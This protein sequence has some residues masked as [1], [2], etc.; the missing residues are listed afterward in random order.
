MY[1]FLFCITNADDGHKKERK[2]CPFG[3]L[4][5]GNIIHLFLIDC[6]QP[7]LFLIFFLKEIDK[8]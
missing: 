2:K 7:Y 1:I 3:P 6:N 5:D 4:P 8:D